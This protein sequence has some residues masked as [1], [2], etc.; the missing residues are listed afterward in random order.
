[1]RTPEDSQRNPPLDS[2]LGVEPN[3]ESTNNREYDKFVVEKKQEK[4]NELILK[5]VIYKSNHF[6]F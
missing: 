3:R 6:I 5:V 1:V 4:V 2:Q